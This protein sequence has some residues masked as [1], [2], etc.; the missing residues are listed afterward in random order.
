M[1]KIHQHGFDVIA[2]YP[3]QFGGAW[4]ELEVKL[5]CEP[6]ETIQNTDWWIARV[7]VLGSATPEGKLDWIEIPKDHAMHGQIVFWAGN[8]PATNKQINECWSDW[9]LDRP[10]KRRA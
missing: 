7:H 10:R 4:V 5:D 1:S 8:D 6:D 3:V 9:L 2:C